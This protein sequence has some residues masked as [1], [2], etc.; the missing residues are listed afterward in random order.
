MK[1]GENVISYS[2]WGTDSRYVDGALDNLKLAA[3]IYPGWQVRIYVDNSVDKD[4]LKL[5]HDNGADIRLVKN[6]KG[7]F[8][9]AFWR[10]L[11]NDDATVNNFMIRDI[12]A[13]LN[14]REQSAVN[15]WLESGKSFHLMRDHPNHR[16]AIQAGMW[17][18][19]ANT[20]QIWP[21]VNQWN[22]Y[23]YYSCDEHFLQQVFYPKI[24]DM[25]LVHD[26]NIENKPFPEHKPIYNGG[27]FVGQTFLKGVPQLV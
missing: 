20:I 27:T 14:F 6:P 13:R 8:H 19:K 25:C 16:Y 22:N 10:F 26:P 17:G 11:V 3:E 24:K 9:G 5:I 1:I 21:L 7:P 4:Q 2:L 12:D 15:E 18:G 23:G